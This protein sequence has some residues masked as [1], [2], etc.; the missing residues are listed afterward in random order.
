MELPPHPPPPHDTMTMKVWDRWTLRH[1]NGE[2]L[3]PVSSSSARRV[4]H[5]LPR[6]E[7]DS[8]GGG[9]GGGIGRLPPSQNRLRRCAWAI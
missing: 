7:E 3:A 1:D 8:G 5:H 9:G 6:D 2:N 4:D